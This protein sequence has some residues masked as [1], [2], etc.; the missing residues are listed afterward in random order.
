MLIKR[1]KEKLKKLDNKLQKK[2]QFI[3][4]KKNKNFSNQSNRYILLILRNT[5]IKMRKVKNRLNF[6]A[7]L[8]QLIKNIHKTSKKLQICWFKELWMSKL[9]FHK[10]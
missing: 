7:N 1:K 4:K 3:K 8:N 2:F 9:K 6:K 5:V 10:S